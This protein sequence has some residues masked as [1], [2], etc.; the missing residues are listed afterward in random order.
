MS[1]PTGIQVY[2]FHVPGRPAPK[3]STHAF[4]VKAGG[5]YTGQT[6]TRPNNSETLY[7]WQARVTSAAQAVGMTPGRKGAGVRIEVL[8]KFQRPASHL[9]KHGSPR[10][11]APYIVGRPDLDKL[12]RALLDGLTGVAYEDDAEVIEL[13]A[14]KTW[15]LG[16]QAEGASVMVRQN[17]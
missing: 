10:K 14:K 13:I 2:Q 3:G 11:S 1:A 5:K 7:A 8:F 6:I 4:A 12:A 9:D 15:A 16:G 17:P